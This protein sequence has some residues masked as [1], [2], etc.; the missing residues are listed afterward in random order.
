MGDHQQGQG[1]DG[2]ACAIQTP[3]T[4]QMHGSQKG[5]N[6]LLEHE[7]QHAAVQV[8]FRFSSNQRHF[9]N[10]HNARPEGHIFEAALF[11]AINPPWPLGPVTGNSL[12]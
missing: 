11:V 3:P 9:H 10:R 6:I 1:L 8:L 7:A 4:F 5:R 12:R 2:A